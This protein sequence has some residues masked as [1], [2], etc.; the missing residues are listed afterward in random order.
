MTFKI[1]GNN[2]I[3]RAYVKIELILKDS[4]KGGRQSK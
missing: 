4:E 2:L 1:F 3:G